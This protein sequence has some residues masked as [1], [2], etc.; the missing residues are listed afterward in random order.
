MKTF[1]LAVYALAG[2]GAL[3]A[4]TVALVVPG[5]ALPPDER[6]PLTIH[7]IREEAA[8]FVFIG[9]MLLWCTRNFERRRPVH[10][11]LLVFTGLFAVIH[12]LGYFEDGRVSLSAIVN[13]VPFLAFAVTI[14]RADSVAGQPRRP[15]AF[16]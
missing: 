6:T 15:A 12:W 7:L 14:P 9:M 4:G 3:L 1:T 16:V 5:L 8:A 10:L 2:I 13:T 11:G